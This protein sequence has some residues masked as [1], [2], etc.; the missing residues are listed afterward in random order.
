MHH[1]WRAFSLKQPLGVSSNGRNMIDSQNL[2]HLATRRYGIQHHETP[3]TIHIPDYSSKI[4]HLRALSMKKVP[5]QCNHLIGLKPQEPLSSLK[6][7]W[8]TYKFPESQRASNLG[9]NTSCILIRVNRGDN[10]LHPGH[11]FH[12]YFLWIIGLWNEEFHCSLMIYWSM[13]KWIGDG[14]LH[15]GKTK[16]IIGCFDISVGHHCLVW[17]KTYDR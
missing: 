12:A 9:N 11:L 7:V 14:N 2:F 1:H 4:P 13:K 17:V 10:W 16:P 3:S 15:L 5:L 6:L 8:K